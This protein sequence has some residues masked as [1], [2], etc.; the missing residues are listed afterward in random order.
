M[1]FSRSA[2]NSGV[3]TMQIFIWSAFSS[4]HSSRFT[5]VGVFQSPEQ[6]QQAAGVFTSLRQSVVDW[7]QQPDNF[8]AREELAI[9]E[10]EPTPPELALAKQLGIYWGPL[11]L[12]WLWVGIDDHEPVKVLDNV[13]FLDGSDS[14]SGAYPANEVIQ[15]LGGQ[16]LVAGDKDDE[17]IETTTV[18]L[19]LSCSAPDEATAQ[20]IEIVISEIVINPYQNAKQAFDTRWLNFVGPAECLI[21][22]GKM[23][24]AGKAIVVSC[25]FQDIAGGFPVLLAYLRAH[26]CTD[27]RYEFTEKNA[28]EEDAEA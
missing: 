8:A 9:S 18:E 11:S 20:A 3:L 23:Q 22:E 17:G 10:P 2:T 13:V 12:D 27:I 14:E 19:K 16:A 26:G 24:R 15:R 25:I 7:Y 1:S 6:A 21:Y 28:R 4:N 5:V